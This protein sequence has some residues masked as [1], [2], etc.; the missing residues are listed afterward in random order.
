VNGVRRVGTRLILSF[1]HTHVG[2]HAHLRADVLSSGPLRTYT[3]VEDRVLLIRSC[4]YVSA[5]G[6]MFVYVRT[7]VLTLSVYFEFK[8]IRTY[9]IYVYI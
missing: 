2:S 1:I 7:Y 3:Y 8:A 6:Q 4:T 5:E 9:I